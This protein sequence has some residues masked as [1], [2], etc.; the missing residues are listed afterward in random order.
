MGGVWREYG[1]LRTVKVDAGC[2]ITRERSL[3]GVEAFRVQGSGFRVQGSGFRVEVS[4]F[5]VSRE[6]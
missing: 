4:R 6:K 1:G 2:F 5:R 3:F